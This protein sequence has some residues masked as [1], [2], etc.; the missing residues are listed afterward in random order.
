MSRRITDEQLILAILN[1]PTQKKAADELGC[2]QMTVSRRI[3]R[4]DFRNKLSE[5]R[6]EIYDSVNNRLVNSSCVAVDVLVSLL[7]SE[8]EYIQYSAATKILQ[9]SQDYITQS[10]IMTKL[11]A[12]ESK[13]CR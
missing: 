8:S 3:N 9:L 4:T 2:S 13:V 7:E 10:D 1:N 5:K 11:E 12:L 6:R